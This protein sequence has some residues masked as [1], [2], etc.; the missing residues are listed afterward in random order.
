MLKPDYTHNHREEWLV[1]TLADV[2]KEPCELGWPTSD[3]FLSFLAW[4]DESPP[5]ETCSTPLTDYGLNEGS[6][7]EP[8]ALVYSDDDLDQHTCAA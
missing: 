8:D 2:S 6:E 7:T 5:S 1:N 3:D 4:G